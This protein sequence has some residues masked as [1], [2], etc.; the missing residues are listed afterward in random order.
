VHR[1]RTAADQTGAAADV[2]NEIKTRIR[3]GVYNPGD[4]LPAERVLSEEL[5]VSRPTVR[6]AIRALASM[7]IV[8]QRHGSGVYIR[9]L[10]V[11]DLLEPVRF[12]L[13][14]SEPTLVSLFEIR[15]AL[16]PIG[17]RLAAVRATTSERQLL[18]GTASEAAKPRVSMARFLELDTT[19]HETLLAAARDDLLRTMVSSLTFLS[20]ASRKRTVCQAGVR[21]ATIRDHAAIAR[22]VARGNGAAAANAMETHLRRLQTASGATADS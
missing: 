9:S 11:F 19:L 8:S 22:A 17:A 21:A 18:L 10:D 14:L 12:A 3:R 1:A 5:G 4:R 15:I 2:I 16:E 6:E 20:Y 13:E 7:N